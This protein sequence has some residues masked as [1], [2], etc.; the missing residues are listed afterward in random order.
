MSHPVRPCYGCGVFDDHPRHVVADPLNP[1]N[2]ELMHMDCCVEKRNC[3]IC[4]EVLA[5]VDHRPGVRGEALRQRLVAQPPA[6]VMHAE[7]ESPFGAVE[8]QSALI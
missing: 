6:L 2:E 7:G 1:G 4:R 8:I 5:A 3:G